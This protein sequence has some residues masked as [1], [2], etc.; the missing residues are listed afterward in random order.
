MGGRPPV[1]LSNAVPVLSDAA[2][3]LP[4]AVSVLPNAVSVLPNAVSLLRCA[5]C[6]VNQAVYGRKTPVS[7]LALSALSDSE[8]INADIT[9]GPIML[10]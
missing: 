1:L 3:V 5:N 7:T 9:A 2:S 10:A 4:N 8:S 6:A